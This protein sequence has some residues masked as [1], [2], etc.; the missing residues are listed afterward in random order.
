MSHVYIVCLLARDSSWRSCFLS[1]SHAHL[2]FHHAF[3]I[4]RLHCSPDYYDCRCWLGIWMFSIE[5]VCDLIPSLCFFRWISQ[6][7]VS[8]AW[9]IHTVCL[10][11]AEPDRPCI[12]SSFAFN[13]LRVKYLTWCLPLFPWLLCQS[14]TDFDCFPSYNFE[15]ITPSAI[16]GCRTPVSCGT[17]EKKKIWKSR[18]CCIINGIKISQSQR[19]RESRGNT[20]VLLS[21]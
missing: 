1:H 6:L 10:L 11:F 18:L 2:M 12:A 16:R 15:Q 21:Q 8:V 4:A 3:C 13:C 19:H 9:N 14:C 7:G 20:S 17:E 5:S